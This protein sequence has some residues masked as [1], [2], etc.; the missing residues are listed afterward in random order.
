MVNKWCVYKVSECRDK[1]MAQQ[2]I[3]QNYA[4]GCKIV[5]ITELFGLITSKLQQLFIY[6]SKYQLIPILHNNLFIYVSSLFIKK[7]NNLYAAY[8]AK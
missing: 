7:S 4:E 6:S 5:E 3:F 1:I 2:G 8:I